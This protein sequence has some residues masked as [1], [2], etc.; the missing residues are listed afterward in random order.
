[1]SD[2]SE[3]PTDKRL[4]RARK[5]GD[6]AKSVHATVAASGLVWW[7]FL[8]MEAPHM[9]EMCA[10]LI[11]RVTQFDDTRTFASRLGDLRG[12]VAAFAPTVFATLG[13]GALAV[14]VPEL[15]QT[16]GALAWKRAAPDLKRMN[17]V[18]GLK[19]LFGLKML[20]D[21]LLALMQF[22]ILLVIFWH[23]V[24]AWC[25]EIPSLYALPLPMQIA[26]I[27]LSQSS[28]LAMTAASQLVPAAIDLAMQRFLWRRRLR[29]DKNE[30]KREYRDDEGDPHIKG[31]RRQLHRELSR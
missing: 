16:R 19:N 11:E 25:R 14:I 8:I 13:A 17:P 21:T 24:T 26:R 15:A 30:V 18:A 29:M 20:L 28:L 23:L 10:A 7:L 27:G 22:V 9:V 4:R 3:D 6:I 5:D 12:V 31:R 2:K 1:M